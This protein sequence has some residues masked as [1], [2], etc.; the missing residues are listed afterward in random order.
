LIGL[1]SCRKRLEANGKSDKA[2]IIATARKLLTQMN[3]GIKEDR[4]YEIRSPA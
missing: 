3:A 1:V 4:D 2:A